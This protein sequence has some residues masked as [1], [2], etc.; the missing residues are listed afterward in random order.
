[1][2]MVAY[3]VQ[4]KHRQAFR[5]GESKPNGCGETPLEDERVVLLCRFR[6]YSSYLGGT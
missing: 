3:V 2:M 4:E 1:M 5:C 6:I